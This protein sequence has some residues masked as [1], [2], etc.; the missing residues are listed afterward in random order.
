MEVF[1]H[2]IGVDNN[3]TS[4][5]DSYQGIGKKNSKDPIYTNSTAPSTLFRSFLFTNILLFI[6]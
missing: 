1:P 3:A 4:I 6:I 5:R 2:P